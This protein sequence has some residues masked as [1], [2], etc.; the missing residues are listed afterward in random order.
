MPLPVAHGLLGASIVAAL[1]QKPGRIRYSLSLLTGALLA[2]AADLDFLLVAVLGSKTWHRGFTHSIL[3]SLLICLLFL[4][5]FR[6]APIRNVLGYGL[7]YASH[8]LLDYLTSKTGG[9]V[10]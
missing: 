1:H 7:A 4:F 8:G 2:N 10:A 5:V 9:G 3:F 6:N